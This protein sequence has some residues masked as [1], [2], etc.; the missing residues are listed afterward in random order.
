M[1]E[2][3]ACESGKVRFDSK[4]SA[5]RAIAKEQA[6]GRLAYRCVTCDGWHTCSSPNA[7]RSRSRRLRRNPYARTVPPVRVRKP[8]VVVGHAL[9]VLREVDAGNYQH[10]GG[11]WHLRAKRAKTSVDV[12]GTVLRLIADGFLTAKA[13]VLTV[14]AAGRFALGGA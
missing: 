8:I 4:G 14:T 5:M 13:G 12:H 7:G 9:H 1:L 3:D 6:H 10:V 11:R 2:H